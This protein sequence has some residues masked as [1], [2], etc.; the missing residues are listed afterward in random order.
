[1][2]RAELIDNQTYKRAMTVSDYNKGRSVTDL[3]LKN[4]QHGMNLRSD[5]LW[6]D[7]RYNPVKYAHTNRFDNVNFPEQEYKDI[8]G[9][10]W[11]ENEEAEKQKF[12]P[13]LIDGESRA[14]RDHRKNM[15]EAV[16]EVKKQNEGH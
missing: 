12:M 7:D 1:M 13:G 5:S 15:K 6:E 16:A 14:S 9:G 11:G 4:W 2:M 3:K 10:N 8:F